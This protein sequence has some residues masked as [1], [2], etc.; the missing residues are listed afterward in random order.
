VNIKYREG[1]KYQLAED[2]SFFIN[3]LV[4]REPYD[5]G[6]FLSLIGGVLT[7][8]DGYAWDG[9]SGPTIDTPDSMTGSLVH[10]ALYQLIR[11]G[12]LSIVDGD[13]A[14][15]DQIMYDLMVNDGML[16]PR[17]YTWY[18]GVRNFAEGAASGGPKKIITAP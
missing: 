13:R 2:E 12:H 8:R 17:A 11:V 14:L 16:A 9:P 15:A 3:R 18:V 4:G 1:Y 7:I 10:D 5:D 6:R